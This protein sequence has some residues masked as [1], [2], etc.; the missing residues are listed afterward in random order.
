MTAAPLLLAVV[1]A[2]AGAR[3]AEVG[4][5]PVDG[6]HLGLVREDSSV[7]QLANGLDQLLAD[8][9]RGAAAA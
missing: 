8:A 4:V 6:T 5:W 2:L 1:L 7:R 3:P 9:G